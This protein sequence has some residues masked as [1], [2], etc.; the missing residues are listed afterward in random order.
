MQTYFL[1][2][3]AVAEAFDRQSAHF[4]E[5]YGTDKIVQYKRRRV[6]RHLEGRLHPGSLL[7]ELNAGTGEDAIY[8]ASRGHRVHATD[9]SA[10]MLNVLAGKV[11]SCGMGAH[12]TY[13]RCS[14]TRLE[15]LDARGP[16]DAVY[17]NFAGLNCSGEIEKVLTGL[18][19]LVKTGG[20]VTLVV[21]PGFCLWESLLVFRG[22]FRT[23]TRRLR[24][25]KG[26]SA[27]IEGVWF[28]CW[29]YRPRTI[30]RLLQGE[31]RLTAAEGL[32][33]LVPPSYIQGFAD[34]HP[35]SFRLLRWG[36]S[37]LKSS[38]PWKYIGDY[39]ILS[40][41]KI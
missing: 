40:F 32:C 34:K 8:F 19:T 30:I 11:Q 22:K 37:L 4:D 20:M 7:L 27:H 36:E 31:F 3:A 33:T 28:P 41:K 1:N 18:G 35:R 9:I 29:Y 38:W 39:V 13:E 5:L 10:G 14:F 2:E 26:R 23:A 16:Y 6:R 15:S 25:G 24:A 12:I 21:L 17:S